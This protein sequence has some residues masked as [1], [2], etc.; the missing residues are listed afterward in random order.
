M[1]N[2]GSHSPFRGPIKLVGNLPAGGNGTMSFTFMYAGK[3]TI[4]GGGVWNPYPLKAL[5][6]TSP[7]PRV[8][9]AR[10][11]LNGLPFQIVATQV[12]QTP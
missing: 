4:G 11:T 10:R 2:N 12:G 7:R 8:C 5:D 3:L 9:A 1:P 6:A